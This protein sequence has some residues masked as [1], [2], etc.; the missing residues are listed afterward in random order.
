VN[1]HAGALRA[2]HEQFREIED[3]RHFI[4]HGMMLGFADPNERVDFRLYSHIDGEAHW[5][6]LTFTID[7][8][9]LLTERMQPLSSEFT[10][11]VADLS[12]ALNFESEVPD[13]LE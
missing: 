12:R 7:E 4:V 1:A 9:A 3:Y 2:I 8:F 6:N 10:K 11:I 5:G 13:W